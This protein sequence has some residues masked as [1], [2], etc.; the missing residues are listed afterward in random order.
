MTNKIPDFKTEDGLWAYRITNENGERFFTRAGMLWH[1]L[2]QRTN[3]NGTKQIKS[4][5]YVGSINMFKDFQ[6][7][8]DWCQNQKGYSEGFQLDKDILCKGNKIYSEDTCIFVP[9]EINKLFTKRQSNRGLYPIGVTEDP[10]GLRASCQVGKGVSKFLGYFSS[11]E[12]A[13]AAYKT[14][15]EN[16]IKQQ[17][18][19]WKDKISDSAYNALI[20]YQVEITD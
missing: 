9:Q 5:H 6:S 20:N 15:K 7:F 14:F 11:P 3:P 12:L 17:A 10:S 4:P 19:L 2:K 1:G 8:A 13:F 18:E 16:Y